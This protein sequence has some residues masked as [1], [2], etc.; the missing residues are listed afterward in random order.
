MNPSVSTSAGSA[1]IL[2]VPFHDLTRDETIGR[3]GHLIAARVPRYLATANLDFAL[4]ASRDVELQRILLEAEYVLCDGMPLVWASRWLGAPLRERVPGSDLVPALAAEAEKRGWR[5]FILGGEPDSL[6]AALENVRTAHPRLAIDGYSPPVA[7][8][9]ELD[10][11]EIA[12]RIRTARPDLLLVAFGCPKQEK[13][14]YMHHRRLG[15]PVSIGVGA[16]VDFLAGKFRRAPR[17][18]QQVGAEWIFRLL[19]EPRR[20]FR[21]YVLDLAFF[22]RALRRER[23]LFRQRAGHAPAAERPTTAPAESVSVQRWSGEIDAAAIQAGRVPA[24]PELLPGEALALDLS[25]VTFM[26]SSGIG[27]V[28][29]LYRGRVRSGAGLVLVNPS[30]AV[31][32]LLAAL[33]LDR[34]IPVAREAAEVPALLGFRRVGPVPKTDGHTV[35][36]AFVGELT[37]ARVNSHRNWLDD[38]WS[39]R[40]AA[41]RL[42]LDCS[43]IGF[44]DSSGLGLLLHAARL[45]RQR[46]GAELRIRGAGTNLRNVT[47]LARVDALFHF[48][49]AHA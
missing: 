44:I 41:R 13:W 11:E 28:V 29:G 22:V 9:L 34:L 19:Q 31:R 49:D 39:A 17:W 43:Q 15:V 6:A 30:A 27:L 46:E 42:Q 32:S 7:P 5:I 8:L 48:E 45:A 16:T 38:A 24:I 14:I 20:L 10:D 47:R 1:V 25:G 3:I 33:N 40:P 23:K 26:D 21:R 2:G 37:A 18:V 36:V 12:A 4:Q 35:N